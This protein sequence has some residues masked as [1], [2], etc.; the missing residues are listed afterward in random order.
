[1][2]LFFPFRNVF[3]M[4]HDEGINLVKAQL[5]LR[6][7]GLYTDIWSD[8]PPLFTYLLAVAFRFFGQRV[9]VGRALV[10]VMTCGL[11]WAYLQYLRNAWGIWH[12][13]AGAIFIILLPRFMDL[14]VSVMVGLPAIA[15]AMSSLWA[16]ILWHKQ[17]KY[18]WLI[19]CALALALSI[20]TKVF[21]GFLAP[22]FLAGI[23]AGEFGRYRQSGD[24]RRAL[25]P[26]LL[27]GSVLAL[28]IIVPAMIIVKPANVGQL[29]EGHLEARQLDVFRGDPS[30]I[31]AWQLREARLILLLAILGIG[32]LVIS[33]RWLAM[34]AA[35]WMATAY[36]LLSQHVPVWGHQQLL[37]TIPAAALAAGAVGEALR[38]FIA[39]RNLLNL[40]S[41]GVFGLILINR[42]PIA[43]SAFN[44][45][46][47][48]GSVEFRETSSEVKFLKLVREYAPQTQWLVTDLPIFAFYADL[49]MP[50]NLV[51]FSSKRTMTG[52]LTEKD[53]L[54]TIQEYHPEQVL[55]GRF[56]FPSLRH[57]LRKHYRLLYARDLTELYLLKDIPLLEE[58]D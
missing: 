49:P 7:Y 1:M 15:L 50:P 4:D 36:L 57:Y 14:S 18:V 26:S 25:R 33:R 23:L 56:E 19:I 51:V 31:L 48:F 34:Y 29:L 46:P 42:G 52:E 13:A 40:V 58:S 43:L 20:L 45:S 2:F 37:I 32:Y 12:A 30:Y 11:I 3:W 9:N 24:W 35:A 10:L 28:A 22:V 27:F 44:A 53:V 39:G 41:L 38:R 21:T 6:G 54:A 16:L 47:T 8:Q 55:F 17:R 5:V